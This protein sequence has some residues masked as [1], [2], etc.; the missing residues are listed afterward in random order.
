MDALW[1]NWDAL[2]AKLP[3][4]ADPDAPSNTELQSALSQLSSGNPDGEVMSQLLGNPHAFAYVDRLGGSQNLRIERDTLANYADT[5]SARSTILSDAAALDTANKDAVRNVA[6]ISD[7]LV[8]W[9]DIQWRIDDP[10]TPAD[11]R[12][13]LESID[14][15]TFDLLRGSDLYVR[16]SSLRP[17]ATEQGGGEVGEGGAT[18]DD[19]PS[20]YLPSINADDI[21]TAGHTVQEVLAGAASDVDGNPIGIAVSAQD[22]ANGQWQY[23]QDGGV[24][25][26]AIGAVDDTQALL[27]GP[28]DKVRF[29]PNGTSACEASLTYHAWDQTSGVAGTP[30]DVSVTGATSAWSAATDTVGIQV[31]AVSDAPAPA[32][33]ETPDPTPASVLLEQTPQLVVDLLDYGI[34]L[35]TPAGPDG[36]RDGVID[37]S[38]D[39]VN[40][41]MARS[42]FERLPEGLRRAVEQLG[43]KKLWDEL[44]TL[45][46]S[47]DGTINL[48][49]LAKW[50]AGQ[51]QEFNFNRN[52]QGDAWAKAHEQS[53]K[54][55][56]ALAEA[57]SRYER[58]LTIDAA[59]KANAA[60]LD[61]AAA[62]AP[63]DGLV[64]QRDF[65]ALAQGSLLDADTQSLLGSVAGDAN[66][67]AL[68]DMADGA[69]DQLIT[70]GKSSP[71]P[72][73][74]AQ[75][76]TDLVKYGV[77]LDVAG[78]GA[79][80]APDGVVQMTDV[81][82]LASRDLSALPQPLQDLV[83]RLRGTEFFNGLDALDGGAD[84]SI[85]MQA[86]ID[87]AAKNLPAADLAQYERSVEALT[88]LRAN[89]GFLDAAGPSSQTDGQVGQADI[90][91]GAASL[92][93][94]LAARAQLGSVAANNELLGVLDLVDGAAD[95]LVNVTQDGVTPPDV[96]QGEYSDALFSLQG[97]LLEA[98][99]A[100]A[101]NSPTTLYFLKAGQNLN[102]DPQNDLRSDQARDT[103]S[104]LQSG[105]GVT[106]EDLQH[107]GSD[108]GSNNLFD[109]SDADTWTAATELRLVDPTV[110]LDSL[111]QTSAASGGINL[112]TDKAAS[113][114]L[115]RLD[116]QQDNQVKLATLQ[117]PGQSLQE[118]MFDALAND[119]SGQSVMQAAFVKLVSDYEDVDR[120]NLPDAHVADGAWAIAS[121]LA[122]IDG[123]DGTAPDQVVTQAELSAAA[124]KQDNNLPD[125]SRSTLQ[126]LSQDAEFFASVA[127]LN[128]NLDGTIHFESA[129][130]AATL[131]N[132][133]HLGAA[134]SAKSASANGLALDDGGFDES[135]SAEFLNWKVIDTAKLGQVLNR[136]LAD[137][138]I[139]SDL[140]I[141]L[142]SLVPDAQA[143]A[144]QML[145]EITSPYY[146][147]GLRYMEKQG[148][149]AEAKQRMQSD[150]STLATIEEGLSRQAGTPFLIDGVSPVQAASAQLATNMAAAVFN[151]GDFTN[152]DPAVASQAISD[153]LETAMGL[154]VTQIGLRLTGNTLTALNNLEGIAAELR[155][156]QGSLGSISTTL[157][158]LFGFVQERGGNITELQPLL[159]GLDDQQLSDALDPVA[160][161]QTKGL[162]TLL[163]K[164]GLFGSAAG[165]FA[166]AASAY[167]LADPN[168]PAR[169]GSA[170]DRLSASLGFVATLSY[171]TSIAQAGVAAADKLAGRA[172]AS[173]F[174]GALDQ[175]FI[176]LAQEAARTGAG[177]TVAA[178]A[179][180][181][182]A[183]VSDVAGGAI[184]IALGVHDIVTGANS[185][186]AGKITFG[187]LNVASGVAWGAA[188]IAAAVGSAL[189]APLAVFGGILIGVAFIVL[190]FFEASPN[191]GF[192][193][194]IID[195]WLPMGIVQDGAH[196]ALSNDFY[197][198]HVILP[199]DTVGS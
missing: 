119:G 187:G 153:T 122:A 1:R 87:W 6:N 117:L 33:A 192:A 53:G 73:F 68:L 184:S 109:G 124:S 47:E 134:L 50:A 116:G 142:V 164:H 190:R 44:A 100:L 66:A 114:M 89:G 194:N 95:G 43:D 179:V 24:S 178:A 113:S 58:S 148:Q 45:S 197:L 92:A 93:L 120:S 111:A 20:H 56:M 27:L 90:T 30:A 160:K 181:G 183:A 10:A 196:S 135:L 166:T 176:K 81:Q 37:H 60:A 167:R 9:S 84:G 8:S 83:S 106:L 127:S 78:A 77:V 188:G 23:S 40:G 185:G 57:A 131:F 46:G 80:A 125:D 32:P 91:A 163:N 29:V 155:Q 49:G 5:E 128:G 107:L 175:P 137:P 172:V 14:R 4:G 168:D 54:Q 74:D 71:T 199:D 165:V 143:K 141:A 105:A 146:A 189:A 19:A 21:N 133:A 101:A 129:R 67:F 126:S 63:A 65:E 34:V 191:D 98:N 17:Q 152:T 162:L 88:T 36:A 138:Q 104:K 182:L 96:R 35:D 72:Q 102:I 28:S 38:N 169:Q 16:V 174:A 48:S 145:T 121:N 64:A 198:N 149:G 12:T 150:L 39:I 94:E 59:V 123:A 15:P 161:Q 22:A 75:S 51:G 7:E 103:W 115:D 157:S 193:D 132:Q 195:P 62:N 11:L 76:L 130:A 86:V 159:A 82:A 186:D 154:R 70:V 31:Q 26:Q 139:R 170:W 79:G 85:H 55:A 108:D 97:S 177:A 2:V 158:K 18:S 173:T 3:P 41:V 13:M 151:E 42:D 144:H 118:R 52:Q 156:F 61:S 140:A 147:S 25:W 171:S 110:S 136:M 99:A 112:A 69:F 180:R